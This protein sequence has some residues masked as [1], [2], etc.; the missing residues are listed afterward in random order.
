MHIEFNKTNRFSI[1]VASIVFL[2]FGAISS[3]LA[4]DPPDISQSFSLWAGITGT[5]TTLTYHDSPPY[6]GH[7]GR[8]K[9]QTSAAVYL[10]SYQIT[11]CVNIG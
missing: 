4:H 6:D 8:G 1:A 3:V 7:Y 9:T 11:L 2:L 5:G 10:Q